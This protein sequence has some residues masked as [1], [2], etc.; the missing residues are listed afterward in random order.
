MKRPAALL[1][2][3]FLLLY[4]HAAPA[5]EIYGLG[6]VVHSVDP[7][8]LSYSWQLEYRQDLHRHFAAGVSYLNEGHFKGHHRD[9]YTAQLWTRAELFDYRLTVAAGIGPYFF[10]D[11]TTNTSPSGFTD[12]HGWKAMFS[13]A[14]TWHLDNNLLLEVRSNWVKG[15][16]GFNTVSALAGIGYHFE[17]ALE[18]LDRKNEQRLDNEVTLLFGQTIV[19]SFD[20]PRSIAAELEYRRRLT[21]HLEWTAAGLYEGDNRLVR[22]DGLLTQ[23]WVAQELLDDA[24]SVGAGAGLYF[25][26]GHYHSPFQG[27]GARHFLSGVVGLT[28]S[29]R[30]TEHWSVRATWSRIV[31]SYARD[32][33]VLLGGLGYRF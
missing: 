1:L 32:T 26:L 27:T 3:T 15:H 20:S 33:D 16:S 28:G 25:N 9:G 13:G 21:R 14:A 29:Y 19:N 23:L 5:S 6:G 4:A 12:D 24:L 31:T 18:P 30:V 2:L 22:R 7:D 8:D 10:L 11:T 17:P